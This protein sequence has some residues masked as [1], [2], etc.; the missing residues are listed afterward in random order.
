M[1]QCAH[2]AVDNARLRLSAKVLVHVPA[3]VGPEGPVHKVTAVSPRTTSGLWSQCCETAY[4]PT[5]AINRSFSTVRLY[6]RKGRALGKLLE[7]LCRRPLAPHIKV[8]VGAVEP[9]R[10]Q[11]RAWHSCTREHSEHMH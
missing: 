11:C 7:W 3:T 4:D 8:N 9:H 5:A 6:R 1:T 2:H 10:L